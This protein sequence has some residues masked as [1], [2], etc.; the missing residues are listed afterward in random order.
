MSADH[1]TPSDPTSQSGNTGTLTGSNADPLRFAA[2]LTPE[3][4]LQ[5]ERVAQHWDPTRRI[6][7]EILTFSSEE[8]RE[9]LAA[10]GAEPPE[11][12]LK[13]LENL[14]AYLAWRES[15]T[16]L[17]E[18]ARDRLIAVLGQHTGL[19]PEKGHSEGGAGA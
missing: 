1:S 6:A 17:L 15:E 19:L 5:G 11:G 14:Q 16:E 9:K 7:M 3:Q 2:A 10:S 4:V 18:A 8:L 12:L 13:S